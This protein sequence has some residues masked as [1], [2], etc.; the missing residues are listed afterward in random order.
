[1]IAAAPAL[2][3]VSA[4]TGE[5]ISLIPATRGP[6]MA[7][8]KFVVGTGLL[9]RLADFDY[10]FSQKFLGKVEEPIDDFVL[11]RRILSVP[12]CDSAII[13]RAGGDQGVVSSLTAAYHVFQSGVLT[14]N[15]LANVFYAFDIN[16]ELKSLSFYSSPGGYN[17]RVY[18]VDDSEPWQAGCQIFTHNP[19]R[20][21]LS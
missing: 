18:P 11:H 19:D 12:E 14:T 3:L 10:Q 7:Y 20:P 8:E 21:D 2:P 13:R 17:I 5:L 16:R 15:T 1:M 9:V 6:F 4:P